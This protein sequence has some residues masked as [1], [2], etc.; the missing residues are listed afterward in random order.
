MLTRVGSVPP[1]VGD[2]GRVEPEV[3]PPAL[4]RRAGRR[5][6]RCGWEHPPVERFGSRREGGRVVVERAGDGEVGYP[7]R[8]RGSVG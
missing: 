4:G 2:D 8:V 6:R 3:W 5:R 7:V 1:V